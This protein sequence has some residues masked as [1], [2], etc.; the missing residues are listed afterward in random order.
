MTMDLEEAITE[1]LRPRG[2]G[3]IDVASLRKAAVRQ[4]RTIR[5][6]RWVTAGAGLAA[7]AVVVGMAPYVRTAIS[8]ESGT[9]I[10]GPGT[11][12]PPG[13]LALPPADVPGAAADPAAVGTDPS[14][15]HF[16]VDLTGMLATGTSWFVM[17]GSERLS[18][19][20]SDFDHFN[21]EYQ[22]ST[23][24]A[25]VALVRGADIAQPA[26]TRQVTVGGR[27]AT[28]TFWPG[29]VSHNKKA[30]VPTWSVQWQPVDGLW[31]RV[32]LFTT[33]VNDAVRAAEALIV[34]RSQR[35]VAPLKLDRSLAGYKLGACS[36]T[37]EDSSWRISNI[38]VERPDGVRFDIAIGDR[39]LGTV[40][41][42]TP[43]RLVGSRPAMVTEEGRYRV[44]YVPISGEVNL[45]VRPYRLTVEY[46][47]V[48]QVPAGLSDD[49]LVAFAAAITVGP[50]LTDP[51]TWPIT[52]FA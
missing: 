25:K 22:L 41:S 34:D 2:D 21:I 24:P 50:N 45:V 11:D 48:T 36:V 20:T 52:P 10:G 15:L 6:R 8:G 16:D 49:E 14:V 9:G 18:V 3:P 29:V 33:D 42:F 1:T 28:A 46:G 30:D 4:G 47:R 17:D 27:P 38:E 26:D 37:F 40:T 31:A 35:C 51:D 32:D 23:D 7:V 12:R 44:I 39:S 19:R 43:D 5:R 13:V